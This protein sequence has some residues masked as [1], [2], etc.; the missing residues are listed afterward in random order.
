ML[1]PMFLGAWV[2]RQT[3]LHDHKLGIPQHLHVLY[4]HRKRSL[5]GAKEFSDSAVEQYVV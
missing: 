5:Q 2:Q 3:D 1:L 4:A